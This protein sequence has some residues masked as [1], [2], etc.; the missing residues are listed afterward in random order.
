VVGTPPLAAP[1]RESDE[2]FLL[3]DG[4]TVTVCP[5]QLRLRCWEALDDVRAAL[6]ERLLDAFL[7]R[8]VVDEVASDHR[9]WRQRHPD[10]RTH[11]RT[12]RWYV[13]VEW[14]TAVSA[15]ERRLS[16]A[17]PR[18]LV[19]RTSMGRARRRVARALRT[20]RR[21]V[22]D[23]VVTES[24]EDL[25]RWL[26]E[27]HPRSVV[28]IDYGGLVHLLGDADLHADT[29]PTDVS[30]ALDAL[31]AGN[32]AEANAAYRRLVDRWQRVQALEHAN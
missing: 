29:S 32:A 22:D 11:I 17:D 15:D 1:P 4:D 21:S 28:E 8:V 7:P 6:P 5:W 27:F 24:V 16:L 2:A 23:A 26:E 10:T 31:A 30:R 18:E 25:G 12:A 3:A 14:F 13:P 19:Y 20:M 9:R